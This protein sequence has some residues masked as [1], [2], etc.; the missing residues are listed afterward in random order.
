MISLG[1]MLT[2][3]LER[4]RIAT[5]L[6]PEAIYFRGEFAAPP[7]QIAVPNL[8]RRERLY[9]DSAMPC[10]DGWTPADFELAPEEIASYR[11]IYRFFPA[12]A[13][14]LL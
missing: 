1:G 9:L 10:P 2:T 3:G 13:E 12:Y 14:L 11:E 6:L 7:Y 4:D 8:T 5:S